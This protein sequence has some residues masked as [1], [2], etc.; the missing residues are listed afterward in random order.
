MPTYSD[1]NN[2]FRFNA[3]IGHG[4]FIVIELPANKLI[5]KPVVSQNKVGDIIKSVSLNFVEK[6]E[7]ESLYHDIGNYNNKE[8]VVFVYPIFTQAA[9]GENGFYDFYNK[10]CGSNCLTVPI[11]DK[12]KGEYSS[13]A[14]GANVLSLLNYSFITDIIIDQNPDILKNYDKVII[15]HSE[16]VTKTEFNAITQHPHVVFLYPNALYAKVSTNYDKNTI[17]LVRGHGYPSE[18]RNGFDWKYDNS[19][20]EYDYNCNTWNFYHR[21]NYTFLNCYPEYRMLSDAELLRTLKMNDPTDLLGD[22]SNWL[23]YP[24]DSNAT[25]KMI[26]NFD[27]NGQKVPSW[28]EKPALWTINGEISRDDFAAL[29]TYLNNNKIIQ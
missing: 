23:T 24:N 29:I 1:Q 4:R 7:L 27:L 22:I 8:K 6:P 21:G 20:Y 16:Y 9:Y 25:Q 18:T 13:S 15:L 14:K 12:I 26:Q 2:V 10:K 19:K 11:P 5:F 3:D 17:T 28:V